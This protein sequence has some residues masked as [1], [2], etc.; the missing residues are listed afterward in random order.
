M[1]L[2]INNATIGYDI[3][4]LQSAINRLNIEVISETMNKMD[5]GMDKLFQTVDAVWAGKSAIVFKDNMQHD[6]D[7]IKKA[8]AT[9]RDD[10]IASFMQQIVDGFN[11]IDENIVSERSE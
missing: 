5:A 8:L 9:I 4:E 3:Q 6:K 7:S 10:V 11:D 2:T 1:G